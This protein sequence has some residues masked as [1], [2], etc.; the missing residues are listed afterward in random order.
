MSHLAVLVS[1]ARSLLMLLLVLLV[2]LVGVVALVGGLRLD[3]LA[4]L[5]HKRRTRIGS[6]AGGLEYKRGETRGRGKGG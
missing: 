4:K 6:T 3:R 5:V 1:H 2:V